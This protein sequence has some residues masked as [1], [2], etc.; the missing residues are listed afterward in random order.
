MPQLEAY[1]GFVPT[2]GG[3]SKVNG[4]GHEPRQPA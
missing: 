2:E 4:I 1:R 3:F